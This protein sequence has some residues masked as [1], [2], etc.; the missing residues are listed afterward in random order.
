MWVEKIIIE[1]I[2][3]NLEMQSLVIRDK[4]G[5]P[6]LISERTRSHGYPFGIVP[7]KII[8]KTKT[9]NFEILE[10]SSKRPERYEQRGNITTLHIM[11]RYIPLKELYSAVCYW[12]QLP[13]NAVVTNLEKISPNNS[14]NY[15]I[16]KDTESR[17]LWLRCMFSRE[18]THGR[19]LDFIISYK[20]DPKAFSKYEEK[21]HIE[22]WKDDVRNLGF[23][24]GEAVDTLIKIIGRFLIG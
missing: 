20:I 9:G 10:Y 7:F 6:M 24:R 18:E 5:A 12:L 8:S 16:I 2:D 3:E 11:W 22:S 23:M 21:D 1:K 14:R 15:A 4:N 13:T 17:R 19:G